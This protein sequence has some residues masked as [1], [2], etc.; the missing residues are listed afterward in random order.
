MAMNKVKVM[1]LS[2]CF[3]FCAIMIVMTGIAASADLIW[4]PDNRFY[5]EHAEECENMGR[6]FSSNGAGG[7]TTMYTSPEAGRKVGTVENGTMLSVSFSY[8]DKNGDTWGVVYIDSKTGWIRMSDLELI[9]DNVS[10]MKDYGDEILPDLEEFDDMIYDDD[11][12]IW[13][14]PG[15]HS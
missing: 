10:F 5:E 12:P 9:Y 6:S 15:Y 13:S 11:V 4:T 14:Y 1:R 3:L 7:H 2:T 8:K